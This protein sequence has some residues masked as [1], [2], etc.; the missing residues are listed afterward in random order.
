MPPAVLIFIVMKVSH[1]SRIKMAA[2]IVMRING[3]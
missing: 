3:Y 1:F 2:G